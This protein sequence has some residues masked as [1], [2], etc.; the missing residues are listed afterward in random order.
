MKRRLA[1]SRLLRKILFPLLRKIDVSVNIKHDYSGRDFNILSWSHKGYWFYGREREAN[2]L[3][4]FEELI[5]EGDVVFE[6][7]GHVGYLTQVFEDLVG[8]QGTVIVAEPA[9][10][11]LNFLRLNILGELLLY[12]VRFLTSKATRCFILTGLGVLPTP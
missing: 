1:N 9:P 10:S 4:M 2:E 3:A 6:V 12:L 5:Q 11:N 7:G 8:A